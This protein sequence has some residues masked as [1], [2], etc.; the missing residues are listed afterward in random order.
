[1]VK[2]KIPRN[3]LK[4]EGNSQFKHKA[5]LLNTISRK[6]IKYEKYKYQMQ[7]QIGN[8]RKL[9][10]FVISYLVL[11]SPALSL[12]LLRFNP[13]SVWQHPV[14]VQQQHFVYGIF[15]SLQLQNKV[16]YSAKRKEK[17]GIYKHSKIW[18]KSRQQTLVV[19]YLQLLN[20]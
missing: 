8:V 20:H 3:N 19:H 15:I 1:M 16:W 17:F 11:S 18:E 2:T 9:S 7:I 6:Q 12:L 14:S 4:H 13:V 5:L 10:C